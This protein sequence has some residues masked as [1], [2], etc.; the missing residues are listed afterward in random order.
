MLKFKSLIDGFPIKPG[1][2]FSL[3]GSVP[4][5][6]FTTL[7]GPPRSLLKAFGSHLCVYYLT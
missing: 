5:S 7:C 3:G 4:S 6:L 2:R 1:I